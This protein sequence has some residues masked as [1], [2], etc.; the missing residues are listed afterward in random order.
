MYNQL[1]Q[2]LRARNNWQVIDVVFLQSQCRKGVFSWMEIERLAGDNRQVSSPESIIGSAWWRKSQR[3]KE[4]MYLLLGEL[5]FSGC[6]EHLSMQQLARRLQLGCMG[7]TE[8]LFR[9]FLR[10]ECE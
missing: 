5:L 2:F 4:H 3:R 1:E 6:Q 7:R 10:I 8:R 9:P